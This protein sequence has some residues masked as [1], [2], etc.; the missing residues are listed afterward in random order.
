MSSSIRIGLGDGDF[1]EAG[2]GVEAPVARRRATHGGLERAHRTV[3]R[4]TRVERNERTV[5][6]SRSMRTGVGSGTKRT[7]RE[8]GRRRAWI[9]ESVPTRVDTHTEGS[10]RVRASARLMSASQQMLEGNR[11]RHP[12]VL[13]RE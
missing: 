7:R 10:A 1:V 2:R 4:K 6:S 11:R 9:V 3:P 5:V 13:T 12:S 8:E